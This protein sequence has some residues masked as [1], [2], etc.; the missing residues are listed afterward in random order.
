M[1]KKALVIILWISALSIG[2][3]Q[4]YSF[5]SDKIIVQFD[6]QNR[7]F[8]QHQVTK[9]QTI[10]YL[11][12]KYAISEAD[13]INFNP[14]IK[15]NQI[16]L[17]QWLNIPVDHLLQYEIDPQNSK[18]YKSVYYKIQAK[19]TLLS[20]C[21][22]RTQWN[23]KNLQ[24]QNNLLNSKLQVNQIIKI[25]YLMDF[26]IESKEF[27]KLNSLNT[28]SKQIDSIE[29]PNAGLENSSPNHLKNY[30]TES[31]GITISSGPSNGRFYVLHNNA[32]RGTLIEI[33]N[34]ILEK[35]ILA[36]VIGKIPS[37]YTKDV[38]AVVSGSVAEAIGAISTKFFAYIRY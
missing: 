35:S 23:S 11:R 5:E 13:L 9:G 28:A 16:I 7:P 25:A 10:F 14:Q 4:N 2:K 33:Y 17:N 30:K 6:A 21:K 36:K 37:N 1:L 38:Q 15:A 18:Q 22:N 26:K 3:T 31:R 29:S 34:P 8:I 20:I 27:T 24:A 32:R 19:E 12:T